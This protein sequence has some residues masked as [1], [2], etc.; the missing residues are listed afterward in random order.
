MPQEGLLRQMDGCHHKSNGKDEWC[1]IAAIDDATSDIPFAEFF[2][3][4]ETTLNCMKVLEEIIKRKGVPKAIYTDKAGWAGGG[5]RTDFSQ[6]KRACEK[7]GIQIIFADSPEAK[8]RIERTF[9]TFQDRLIPE[10]RL[11]G[12]TEVRSANRY[13]IDE[14][15]EKYWKNTNV[16]KAQYP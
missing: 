3:N 7:L 15:V 11:H 8:G 2:E 1:L 13:L 10:L 5:K 6:F 12:F 9:R 16:V 14:F 4:G